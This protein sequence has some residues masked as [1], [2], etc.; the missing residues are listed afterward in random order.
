MGQPINPKMCEQQI[1]GGIGQAIGYMLYEEIL[2]NNGAVINPD[3]TDYKVPTAMEMP[4]NENVSC[5]IAFVPHIEGPFGA[6]GLGEGVLSPLAPA[7]ANAFHNA[8]GVRI[9]EMPLTK[10]RVWRALR[11]CEVT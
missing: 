1:E 8:T 6:K 2:E 9:M 10:E 4:S 7:L 3:F 11:G 5:M